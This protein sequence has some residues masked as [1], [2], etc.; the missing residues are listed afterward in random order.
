MNCVAVGRLVRLRTHWPELAGGAVYYINQKRGPYDAKYFV[1]V[2][3]GYDRTRSWPLVVKLPTTQ[4]F[5]TEPP[6]DAQEIV[7]IYTAWIKDELALHNDAVVVMPLLDLKELYGPGYAGMNDALQPIMDVADRVNID[8][9]RVYLIGH[10]EAAHA[11]WNLAL[12]CPTYFAAI[13]PLAG[14]ASADWQRLRLANLSNVLP[15]VWCDDSDDV[16]K[17]QASK[18]LVKALRGLK[19]DVELVET[20]MLGHKPSDAVLEEC[21]QKTRARTRDL[22]PRAVSIQSN[23]PDSIFNRNDWVQIWQPFSPGD[24]RRLYFRHGSGYM[25]VDDNSWRLDASIVANRIAVT[26]DNVESFRLYVND[27]MMDLKQPVRVEVNKR[28]RFEGMVKPSIAGML[29]DQVVLG[30]GWRYYCGEIDID[31]APPTTEP[32]TQ[33]TTQPTTRPH[34]GR[35]IV[36]PAAEQ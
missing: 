22:Y 2:P 17:P 1:G 24:D 25:V 9:A 5:A 11:T 7:R 12:H 23:R 27:Q 34:K 20:K 29:R 6:P 10:S 16:V 3:A 4:A 35:I 26:T 15:V 36:G 30:R 33:T 32:T 21:Y 19:Q 13:N 14:A 28:V 18:S 8:P 31:L